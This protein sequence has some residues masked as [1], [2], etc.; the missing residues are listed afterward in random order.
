[1]ADITARQST[2]TYPE[3]GVIAEEG[4]PGGG[5]YVLLQG[6]VAVYKRDM[7][8]AEFATRGM[9]F[10]EISS[11]LGRPR[12]ARLVALEPTSVV[13]FEANIDELIA[14]HP[15]VAK[16]VLVSLAQRLERTTDALWTALQA[17]PKPDDPV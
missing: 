13:H 3:S 10:G 11:I 15:Q 4:S 9:V 8:V 6:R 1:M 16:T 2:K 17:Q 7:K 14:H 12:T 5:W